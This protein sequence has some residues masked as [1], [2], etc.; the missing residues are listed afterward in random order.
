MPT[1]LYEK[2][3]RFFFYSNENNEPI[4]VH[5]KKGEVEGK[6]WL[7]PEMAVAW[8]R[9][10]TSAEEKDIMQIVATNIEVFKTKWNEYFN[11]K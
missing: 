10:F 1:L 2:G 8:F 3:F 9:G 4:H 6:I 7:E 5:V 11:S